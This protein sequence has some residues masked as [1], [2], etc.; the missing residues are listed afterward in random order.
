MPIYLVRHGHAGSRSAWEGD[1]RRRPLS[2]KGRRQAAW[3]AEQL[4][5][6]KVRRIV[7]SPFLRCTETVEPLAAHLGCDV[8]ADDRLAEGAHTQAAAELLVS[9][10]PKTVVA[11]S[12]GDLIPKV[13]RYLVA[14]GMELDGALLDAKG[15]MWVLDGDDADGRPT[16]SRYVP[17]P[18]L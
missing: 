7:S 17:P 10:S 11:C 13:L 2:D 8:V 18:K 9:L 16:R 14:G 3:L 15:S 6:E 5:D 1:D 4:G 12:H